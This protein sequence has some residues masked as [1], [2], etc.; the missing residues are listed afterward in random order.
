MWDGN[1]ES[2]LMTW[3]I[4]TELYARVLSHS[5]QDRAKWNRIIK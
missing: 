5:E 2:K 1:A 3:K 4:G